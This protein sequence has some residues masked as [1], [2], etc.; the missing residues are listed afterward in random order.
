MQ[1]GGT[2]GDATDRRS[3]AKG[4]SDESGPAWCFDYRSPNTF[5]LVSLEIDAGVVRKNGRDLAEL[6]DVISVHPTIIH[7]RLMGLPIRTD[8]ELVLRGGEMKTR[9]GG[10]VRGSKRLALLRFGCL[11][12]RRER[13][14]R[15]AQAFDDLVS[16]V[17][18]VG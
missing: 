3:H 4:P 2:G 16:S 9:K 15:M 10:S 18:P 8:Y 6:E 1:Q 13:G 5:R 14:R 12:L 11:N 7:R 17:G